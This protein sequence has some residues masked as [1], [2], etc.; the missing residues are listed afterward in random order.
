MR[1]SGKLSYLYSI[2]A[3]HACIQTLLSAADLIKIVA[4]LLTLFS[5]DPLEL[6][7]SGLFQ[8]PLYSAMFWRPDQ[9]PSP[10]H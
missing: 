10:C 6:R 9:P 2:T 7:Q 4:A 8:R 3:K 5:A 1:S